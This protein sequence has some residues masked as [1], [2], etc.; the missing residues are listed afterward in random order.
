MKYFGGRGGTRKL[1]RPRRWLA[2]LCALA[3]LLLLAGGVLAQNEP[4]RGPDLTGLGKP[5]RSA[6]GY[7]LSWW[8]VDGGGGRSASA[9]GE[10][11]LEGT[12]GQPDAGPL[13]GTGY[14]VTGGFW[15]GGKVIY[16]VYLPLLM[17]S[18]P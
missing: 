17:R 8:T 7:G 10:Y 1:G 13:T 3:A 4:G 6:G 5:V 15:V 2:V 18:Y 12:I 16:D 11:H 9:G 14:R